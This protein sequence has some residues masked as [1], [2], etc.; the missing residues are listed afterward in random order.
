MDFEII[1]YIITPFII[2]I[3]N[4]LPQIF[5]NFIIITF[6]FIYL[7][8][9]NDIKTSNKSFY[10]LLI[11]LDLI[12]IFFLNFFIKDINFFKV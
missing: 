6:T 8:D 4:N 10:I 12:I 7:A 2:V 3:A 9:I 11:F 1:F 5:I